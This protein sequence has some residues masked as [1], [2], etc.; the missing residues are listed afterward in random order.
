M[1]LKYNYEYLNILGHQGK[2]CKKTRDS[3]E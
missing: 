3:L 1:H 2:H